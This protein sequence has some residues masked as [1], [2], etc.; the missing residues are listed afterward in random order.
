M[1]I[2]TAMRKHLTDNMK[3]CQNDYHQTEQIPNVGKD[4]EKREPLYAADSNVN[5]CSHCGKQYGDFSKNKTKNN[6]LP[7]DLEIPLL[8]I[9]PKK[10][11]T[12]I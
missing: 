2:K 3:G 6:Q 8:D 1:R 11:N 5:W 10:M 9:Y 7:Y 12:L 4:V